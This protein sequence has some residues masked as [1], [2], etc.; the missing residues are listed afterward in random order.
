MDVSL[1]LYT[2]ES[3]LCIADEKP[4]G[5]YSW[6]QSIARKET[7]KMFRDLLKLA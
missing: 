2:L 4:T 7:I 1:Y 3:L 5:R 6:W